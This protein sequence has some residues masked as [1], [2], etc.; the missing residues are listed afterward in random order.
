VGRLLAPTSPEL[1]RNLVLGLCGAM[2][3]VSVF[4]EIYRTPFAHSAT[5]NLFGV[6]S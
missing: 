3:F 6:L 1:R 5:A 2:L 4:F